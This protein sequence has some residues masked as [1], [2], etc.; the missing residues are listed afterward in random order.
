MAFCHLLTR[1]LDSVWLQ[2][3]D[4][5]FHDDDDDD[6]DEEYQQMK[7]YFWQNL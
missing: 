7:K 6:D 3:P 1:Q 5:L 2:W 4:D